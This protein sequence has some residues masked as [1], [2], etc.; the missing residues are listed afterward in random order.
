[1]KI[2]EYKLL[3]ECCRI[4]LNYIFVSKPSKKHKC[5]Y[6][7]KRTADFVLRNGEK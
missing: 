3:C 1:M 7:G 4:A 6:C 5:E 2:K